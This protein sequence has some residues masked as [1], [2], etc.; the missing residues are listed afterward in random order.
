MKDINLTCV[1]NAIVD[2][3]A[4]IEDNFL[5]NNDLKK[6]SM[7]II[8]NEKFDDLFSKIKSYKIISGGS[9]ANTAVGF[10][11]F[12]GRSSFIGRIGKDHFAKA[13]SNDLNNSNVKF[14]NDTI[15]SLISKTS[16]SLILVSKDGERTM[17][18]NLDASNF[19]LFENFDYSIFKKGNLIYIEG[20]LFDLEETKNSLIE[21]C[22]IAKAFGLKLSLSLSD[23]FCVNR[24]RDDFILLIKNYIDILF[25]NESELKSLCKFEYNSAKSHGFLR[26]IVEKS[27][28][29]FGEKGSKIFLRNKIV[30][31]K[32]ISTS[33]VVDTTGAGDLY[34]SGFLFGLSQNFSL[35]YSGMLASKAASEIIQHY[36]ARPEKELSELLKP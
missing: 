22:K 31:I 21:L 24:H 29:T 25:A 11:S 30:E 4:N 9:A 2:I 3:I 17:C 10:A 32:A 18:T 14:F 26:D 34:A 23:S 5:I 36:G 8:S 28:I 35:E 19:L 15:S 33:K 12:G 27:V 13:F 1:G 7:T 20:Y 6:G 16:K